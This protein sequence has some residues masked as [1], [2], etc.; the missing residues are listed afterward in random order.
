MKI[1]P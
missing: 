1:Y